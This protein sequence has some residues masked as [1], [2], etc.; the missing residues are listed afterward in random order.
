MVPPPQRRVRVRRLPRVLLPPQPGLP[1]ARLPDAPLAAA[2]GRRHMQVGGWGALGRGVDCG[3]PPP[4]P[5]AGAPARRWRRCKRPA[6]DSQ[7]P[8][9]LLP[10]RPASQGPPDVCPPAAARPPRPGLAV[11][12]LC[13]RVGAGRGQAQLRRPQVGRGVGERVEGG[14]PPHAR[15]PGLSCATRAAHALLNPHCPPLNLA[16]MPPRP[17]PPPPPPPSRRFTR[18]HLPQLLACAQDPLHN[19]WWQGAEKPWQALACCFEI[20]GALAVRR[21]AERQGGRAGSGGRASGGAGC[22]AACRLC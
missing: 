1:G 16:P 3:G 9:T 8:G 21:R 18:T 13:Q 2:P 7:S 10:P 5:V 6:C 22:A 14:A 17:L 12:A 20:A 15:S 4:L 11:C 19:V